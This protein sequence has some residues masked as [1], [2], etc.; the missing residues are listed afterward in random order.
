MA[1]KPKF[2]FSASLR[3]MDAPEL[4]DEIEVVTGLKPSHAHLK[5]DKKPRTSSTWDNDIWILQSPLN[6]KAELTDHLNWLWNTIKP[7]SDYF[8]EL[9][10][11]GRKVDVF[12]GYRS[13]SDN[14]GFI[15]Q[16]DALEIFASLNIPFQVSCI[17]A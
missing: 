2:C 4:H 17:I 12:C 1:K 6:E 15:V 5:G 11:K 13:D 14:A 16:P 3:V 8:K 10:Q 7:H 9:L